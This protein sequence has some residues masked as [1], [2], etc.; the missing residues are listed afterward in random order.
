M[1]IA[2]QADTP[3]I[4][5]TDDQVSIITAPPKGSLL[6]QGQAGAG[7][8]T[9][10]ALR[11]RY[12]V[13]NGVP[14][15]S[16]LVLVPQR[17]LAAPYYAQ[18]HAPDFP[19][20]GQ[21]ALLT[22]NGLAQRMITLFWP[23]ISKNA[24]FLYPNAPFRF[25]TIET[26]QYYLA[27]LVEP[28]LQQGYFESL[29]IDPNR[30]FSQILDNLNK[31]AIVGFPPE[32]I[33]SRLSNAWLGKPSQLTIYQQAG[34]CAL[35]FRRFCLDHN[36]LD[37]SLQLTVF[38]EQLWPALIC[39]EYIHKIYHHLIYDNI[40]EDYP[41][42]HDFAADLIPEL[43]STLLIQDLDGGYRSFLG[44]D[45]SS[46]AGL[47]NLCT[48][49]ITLHDSLVASPPVTNLEKALDVSIRS[50]RLND[51]NFDWIPDAFTI[52]SFR[53]YPE[54]MD[55]IIFEIKKL[56]VENTIAP[57][58]IAVLTP[59][60]SDAL[61]FSFAS[62]FNAADIPFSTHR[63]SRS[64]YD[65]PAVRT[66]LTLAK[67]AHP[68]WGCNPA[69]NEVRMA[70]A[71]A[72]NGLDFARAD[73]LSRTL[74]R[75]TS[76]DW[77]LN[78]FDTLQLDM[79]ERITFH[80]GQRFDTLRNWLYANK[81]NGSGELDY[82]LSRLYGEVLSQPGF[83][84]HTDYD[85]AAAIAH[86][87]DSCRK[88]RNIY[89]PGKQG[90][91]KNTGNEYVRVL[92]RGI[93]AAQS[94]TAQ[95]LSS[96]SDTV[97]LG[98]AFSFLMRNQPVTRQFWVDIGSQ[99]W[100][101]RLEQ[102][103]TQPYV[104]SRHWDLK[105]QWTDVDEYETNQRSLAR[106]TTGLLRRCREHVYLCSVSYNERGLEERGQLLLALQNIQRVKARMSDGQDV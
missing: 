39:K 70:F 32:E 96:T 42:A 86:L 23:L 82:W 99:G 52:I 56:I 20:G 57:G 49:V 60:L 4:H 98:P 41:V 47:G 45:P 79:Q 14:G 2:H 97:F 105:R 19:P 72:I 71:L 67:I 31:S 53:F 36:Y 87:I 75:S 15:D 26:A 24:G 69:P 43:T 18:A 55:W 68:S 22:F 29:T 61:R 28:L 3:V 33:A 10:G 90:F 80:A 35:L 85:A 63:P 5:L 84:F 78:A 62:R 58:E 77:S 13:D 30:L 102:P 21:P 1:N 103:L 83:G 16:I 74:Y 40:E 73:L 50:R 9:C 101:S 89:L 93:L 104:L 48:G 76:K 92:E 66:M 6:L 44:A 27:T 34:E 106:L 51:E 91:S 94:F 37:F 65:E 100:W 88:F 54:V 17:S 8:T 12:L 95:N 64:L 25:L 59:F 38:K 11:M 81:E 7:K 46:A